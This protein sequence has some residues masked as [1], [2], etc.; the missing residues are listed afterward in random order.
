M[1]VVQAG[2]VGCGEAKQLAERRFDARDFLVDRDEIDSES[3]WRR[4]P[5][6]LRGRAALRVEVPAL[7]MESRE[8]ALLRG[9]AGVV[10]SL[11]AT[12]I[13]RRP[14]VLPRGLVVQPLVA[15]YARA[16]LPVAWSGS[17]R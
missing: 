10:G 13:R 6:L 2:A 16:V 12:P 17:S 3:C 4:T 5:G 11:I 14:V 8:P 15:G 7:A 1:D 9:A